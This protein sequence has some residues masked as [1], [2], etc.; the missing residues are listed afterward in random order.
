MGS[1]LW[2]NLFLEEEERSENSSVRVAGLKKSGEFWDIQLRW[3]NVPGL[4]MA[5]S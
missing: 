4:L 2:L 5:P 1:K 3:T